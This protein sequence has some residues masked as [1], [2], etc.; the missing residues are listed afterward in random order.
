VNVHLEHRS[1]VDRSCAMCTTEV[2]PDSHT[3]SL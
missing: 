3:V 2:T 1:M